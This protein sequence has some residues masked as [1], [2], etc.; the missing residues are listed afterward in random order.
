[1]QLGWEVGKY[2]RGYGPLCTC[3]VAVARGALIN[4]PNHTLR[5]PSRTLDP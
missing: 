4:Q 1:M 3:L 5:V 2:L